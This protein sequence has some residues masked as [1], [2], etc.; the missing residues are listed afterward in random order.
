MSM[1][2]YS[3][4]G[5]EDTRLQSLARKCRLD[6]EDEARSLSV[7]QGMIEAIA[8]CVSG[9]EGSAAPPAVVYVA[10]YQHGCGVDLSAHASRDDAETR[11]LSI[12]WRQCMR[13]PSIRAAV[14]ARFGPLVSREPPLEPPFEEDLHRSGSL[15]DDGVEGGVPDD[16]DGRG[17][18][19]GRTEDQAEERRRTFCE[20]LLEEWPD[21]ARGESLWI[22][23]CPVESDDQDDVRARARHEVAVD[24]VADGEP[25]G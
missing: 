5:D 16:P 18:V 2:I 8:D 15:H 22:A 10:A 9:R 7:Y 1:D 17:C 3:K 14:D 12:A 20:K 13:D 4:H 24:A 6:A 25:S 21:L 19:D 11:L 23:E